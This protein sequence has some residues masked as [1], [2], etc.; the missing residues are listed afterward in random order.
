MKLTI[1]DSWDGDEGTL[2]ACA[3][4][5]DNTREILIQKPFLPKFVVFRIAKVF[6]V[7]I[8]ELIHWSLYRIFSKET[9]TTL[10]L[11]SWC[12]VRFS[13]EMFAN[14]MFETAW[15]VVFKLFGLGDRVSPRKLICD[16]CLTT[17]HNCSFYY[18]GL[19]FYSLRQ[20]WSHKKVVH[21]NPSLSSYHDIEFLMLQTEVL[22]GKWRGPEWRS[23]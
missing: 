22:S 20:L 16:D 5:N 10:R 4:Y 19:V 1:L 15:S 23:G 14:E 13:A 6:T 7:V 11:S 2:Y 21:K 17:T 18:K 12:N 9:R 8:H 3:V